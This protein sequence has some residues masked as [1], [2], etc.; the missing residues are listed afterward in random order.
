M[1]KSWI[2]KIIYKITEK[3]EC[4]KEVKNPPKTAL[5]KLLRPQDSRQ[6][7]YNNWSKALQIYSGSYLPYSGKE[8]IKQGW[9]NVLIQQNKATFNQEFI[10]PS[11][12]QKVLRHGRH[13]K[14]SGTSTKTHYHWKNPDA[15][16]LAKKE[17]Q[18]N[19]YFD[20]YGEVCARK[21]PESHIK[22]HKTRRKIK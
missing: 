10:K 21:S 4:Y 20:K 3:P 19:F 12:G 15:E 2:D 18:Q 8:L 14:K 16:N 11:T 6:V 22:P 1:A 7:Q 9:E 13:T 17:K 5:S